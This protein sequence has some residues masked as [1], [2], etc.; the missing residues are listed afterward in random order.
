MM[1]SSEKWLKNRLEPSFDEDMVQSL[2]DSMYKSIG[3]DSPSLIV[4]R[5]FDEFIDYPVT[6]D[7]NVIPLYSINRPD[8]FN[9]GSPLPDTSLISLITEKTI[10][11]MVSESISEDYNAIKQTEEKNKQ[12]LSTVLDRTEKVPVVTLYLGSIG[13]VNNLYGVDLI[14][15]GF[16]LGQPLDGAIE[17]LRRQWHFRLYTD[18]ALV[19]EPAKFYLYSNKLPHR[20]DGPAVVYRTKEYFLVY[21]VLFSRKEFD[22]FIRSFP[23]EE[24]LM[25]ISSPLK[26]A[27]M[28]RR[29]GIK[30]N[31]ESRGMGSS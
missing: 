11:K 26:M 2:L 30:R 22:T 10:D 9:N 29:W 5:D 6:K 12:S 24:I 28:L 25:S 13:V 19:L 7:D 23:S 8:R 15:D 16:S 14:N 21:G 17:M 31:I 18:R 3:L 4:V 1:F 20:V 27:V